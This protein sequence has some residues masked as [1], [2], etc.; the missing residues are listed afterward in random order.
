MR[1]SAVEALPLLKQKALMKNAWVTDK[2]RYGRNGLRSLSRYMMAR[3]GCV[4]QF[5]MTSRLID[6]LGVALLLL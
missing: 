1:D 6:L 2:K 5:L 4:R 3:V